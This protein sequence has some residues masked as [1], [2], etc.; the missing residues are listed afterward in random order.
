MH[1]AT[2]KSDARYILAFICWLWGRSGSCREAAIEPT[3]WLQIRAHPTMSN[4]PTLLQPHAH[5]Q[6]LS[7]IILIPAAAPHPPHPSYSWDPLFLLL[8]GEL[9]DYSIVWRIWGGPWACTASNAHRLS[10]LE[11]GKWTPCSRGNC[12]GYSSINLSRPG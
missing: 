6:N 1:T 8:I 5:R 4:V 10:Q 7:Y 2:Y 9:A 3:E 11:E 12:R